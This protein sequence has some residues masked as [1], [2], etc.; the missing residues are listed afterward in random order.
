ML[1]A[2][3]K[4]FIKDMQLHSVQEYMSILAM[5]DLPYTKILRH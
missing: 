1:Q 2:Q 5:S 4:E 3:E